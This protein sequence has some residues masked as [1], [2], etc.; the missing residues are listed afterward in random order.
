[1]A[2]PLAGKKLAVC[3]NRF[4]GKC[5]MT[6]TTNPSAAA[7]VPF[8]DVVSL[9]QQWET[10]SC[11]ALPTD[12]MLIN[13]HIR[14][15]QAVLAIA[16]TPQHPDDAAVD[17]FSAAM[18]AKLANKRAEGYGGW[19]DPAQC[20]AEHLSNLL[21]RSVL[22]GDPVDA[23]NFAMML[24]QRSSPILR[25]KLDV[26]LI[27]AI[28]AAPKGAHG[29]VIDGNPVFIN[30][31]TSSEVYAAMAAYEHLELQA[32]ITSVKYLAGEILLHMPD[33][34]EV[35]QRVETGMAV[36]LLIDGTG[37]GS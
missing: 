22:Q 30:R 15:L 34:G 19:D 21:R 37:N 29:V 25:Q 14:E 4:F 10:R 31:G 20:T 1:M 33:D 23:A 35:P 13:R 18:K 12:A 9:L 28:N 5:L 26:E 36:T 8:A 24:Q 11:N 32:T 3:R 16:A 17:R 7:A 27:A 6:N 2:R